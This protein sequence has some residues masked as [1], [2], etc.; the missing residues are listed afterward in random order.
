MTL[1]F[2]LNSNGGNMSK[3]DK[4]KLLF[5]IS[6][7]LILIW[8]GC[9]DTGVENIPQSIN[10]MSQVKFV[11]Q[12][13][14]A[15]ATV[16][17]DGSSVG[18]IQSGGESSYMEAPSGSRNVVA[19]YSSGSNVQGSIFLETEYKI[20]VSIVEDSTGNRSFVKSLDG[21]VWQ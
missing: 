17:I 11:N 19:N 1:S 9:V 21:Y 14:G 3:A 8:A 7:S 18:T 10:Y 20:T 13:P 16:T 12:V 2:Q 6:I 4:N 5:S 15:D